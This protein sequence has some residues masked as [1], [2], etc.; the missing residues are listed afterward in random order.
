LGVVWI[1]FSILSFTIHHAHRFLSLC[2]PVYFTRSIKKIQGSIKADF[3]CDSDQFGSDGGGAKES[4]E[5]RSPL[6]R[7]ALQISNLYCLKRGKE[8]IKKEGV[9]AMCKIQF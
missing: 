2:E 5:I 4:N 1:L 7:H 3:T 9:W 8:K 6:F